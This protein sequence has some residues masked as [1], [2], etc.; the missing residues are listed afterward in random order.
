MATNAV[1]ESK[2]ARVGLITTQ[3]FQPDPAPRALADAGAARRLDHHDQARSARLARG[4]ARGG[5]A[6]GRARQDARRRRRGAGRVDRARPRRVRRRVA[7]GRAH[8]L[9]R[10]R[11][12]RAR[13]RRARRAPLP[14][15][16]G[17][18]LRRRA[19]RVPR[20]RARADG[21][22]ELVRAP[23]G[24][25]LRE[26]PAGAAER[27]RREGGGQHPPLRCR[28]DDDA[29][30]GAEPDL[31][32]ALGPSGGVAG[33]LFVARKAGFDDI[34]TFDMGGTSTDVALCQDGQPT[35]GRETVDRPVPDQGAVA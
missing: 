25:R 6:H 27:H 28:A 2:G 35:I 13:D 11:G 32:R 4:H 22:H 23:E 8:Q 5:R 29:R 3:G 1:L 16:P 31:R 30:G 18:A 21:V 33:A 7:D 17:D 14:G 12:A 19:A 20:V 24:R 26:A 15:L 34:L 10:E 9:V